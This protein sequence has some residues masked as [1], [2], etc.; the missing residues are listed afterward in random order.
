MAT[1]LSKGPKP[2]AFDIWFFSANAK[3]SDDL[4]MASELLHKVCGNN[5]E[6]YDLVNYHLELAFKA[7]VAIGR[8]GA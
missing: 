4:P 7:G 2:N 1:I 6:K 3:T 8:K 5:A